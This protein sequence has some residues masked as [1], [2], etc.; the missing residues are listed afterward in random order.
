MN[1]LLKISGPIPVEDYILIYPENQF[2]YLE[3]T[4]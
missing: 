1:N 4:K 2:G 3:L